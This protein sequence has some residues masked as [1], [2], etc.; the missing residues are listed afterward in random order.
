MDGNKQKHL[1]LIQGVINRLAGNLFYLKGWA[2]T[3]ITG[4]FALSSKDMNPSYMLIAYFLVIIFWGLDA[5]FLSKERQFRALYND[6]RLLDEKK[7]DFSMDISKYVGKR[8]YG[9]PAS[10]F[11]NTL[12]G[13][14][15]SLALVMILIKIFN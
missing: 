9:L 1:E 4:L 8:K 6:V 3:L 10:I 7:I 2:I 5:Y 11:S 15:G 13:F 14:Y 12:L